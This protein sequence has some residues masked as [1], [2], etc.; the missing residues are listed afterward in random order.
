MNALK[1]KTLLLG[2]AVL[3]ACELVHATPLD[4]LEVSTPREAIPPNIVTTSNKPM[5]MLAT[6]KDHTLFGPIYTDFE[7]LDGD[8]NIDTTFK[9]DFT[10]YGYF[11]AAKCYVYQNNRFEPTATASVTEITNGTKKSKKYSCGGSNQW[12]GNFMNWATMTRLDV[13]RKMLYGGKRST[14]TATVAKNGGGK[15][16]ASPIH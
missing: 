9:P 13:I 14:D 7:D 8:G 16:P 1:K 5:L 11:D 3:A 6:S 10:Y 12:S 15:S 2:M 4:P